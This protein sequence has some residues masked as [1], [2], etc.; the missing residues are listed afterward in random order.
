MLEQIGD[1]ITA[2]ADFVCGYPL[3][4]LLI[5]GGL[6]LFL[7]SGMVS[8]RQ[9]P[10]S[11]AAIRTKPSAQNGQ[12]SSGQA[13]ASV[14]A[15]TI[16]LGNIAGVAI[17]LVIGGP[18][19]IFW[20]WISALVGMCTKFYEGTLA[21][22]Y[23]GKDSEG[24]PAGGPMYI[25]EHGLGAKWK[26]LAI[27]FAIAGMFGTMCIMN[28]NQLT[29]AVVTTFTTP[30]WISSN[31]LLSALSSVVMLDNL[32]TFRLLFGLAVAVV[33]SIV[34]LGG[35]KR[36]AT[37]ATRL[38]PLMV[39]LYFALVLYIIINHYQ[40]VPN[41]IASIFS[42]AFNFKAGL[43]ALLGISDGASVRASDLIDDF[44]WSRVIKNDI[45]IE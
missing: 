8:L 28:A 45:L 10:Y 18:G 16:G 38:V 40:D 15:A 19:A 27:F 1:V 42:E 23:K 34:V 4:I 17:A 24:N 32:Q 20:M 2:V 30:E 9:L 11:I 36:I 22:M 14:V 26:P 6:Y 37:I 41:V 12:I 3:F 31:S 29:E 5:G 33:V 35:I 25:I 39:I 44:D 7:T 43:G 13:L 21:I